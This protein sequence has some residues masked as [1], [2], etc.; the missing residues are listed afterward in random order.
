MLRSRPPFPASRRRILATSR[1][2]GLLDSGTPIRSAL[3]SVSPGPASRDRPVRRHLIITPSGPPPAT[4][5]AAARSTPSCWPATPV[6]I[7]PQDT[8]KE[9]FDW[10]KTIAGQIIATPGRES[11]VYAGDLRQDLG[12]SK[13]DPSMMIFNQFAEMGNPLLALQCPP[14]T[15][16]PDL[17][18]NV[19]KPG[20]RL[21]GRSLHLRLRRHDVRGR[22]PQGSAIRASKLAGRRGAAVTRPS[23]TMASAA[24]SCIEGIGDKH[25]PRVPQRQETPTRSI[26]IDDEDSQT[27]LACSTA[28]K[29][30]RTSSPSA[31]LTSRSKS[32]PGWAFPASQTFFAASSLPSTMS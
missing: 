13:Q 4:T 14:A 18:E 6:A 27:A 19:K 23:S 26:H 7:P 16:R 17:F 30:R 21:A 10:L 2:S 24:A 25:I 1:A 15:L 28:R 20:Q 22:P 9:R 12:S 31:C 5:A 29:A 3:P 11:N 32:S 8:S